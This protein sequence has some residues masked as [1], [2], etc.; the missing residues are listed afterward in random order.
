MTVIMAMR[1]DIRRRLQALQAEWFPRM[2][3]RR[4]VAIYDQQCC[5]RR[6]DM[7]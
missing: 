5:M 2:L 1:G 7:G 4:G 6:G 3:D